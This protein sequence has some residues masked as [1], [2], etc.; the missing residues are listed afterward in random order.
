MLTG[1]YLALMGATSLAVPTQQGQH[2]HLSNYP[3]G[4]KWIARDHKDNVWLD[5]RMDSHLKVLCTSDEQSADRLVQILKKAS[6]INPHFLKQLGNIE[7]STKLEFNRHWGWGSSSTLIDLIAQWS[8]INPHDL[9]FQTLRGSGYDVACARASRPIL[10]SNDPH[11]AWI[12]VE[13][14]PPFLNELF[15]IYLNQKQNSAAEVNRFK[16]SR[17]SYENEIA[18]ISNISHRISNCYNLNEFQILLRQHEDIMSSVLQQA[19]VADK[20][21]KDV[22]GVFKSLGA[23]GGD[24]VLFAGKE[25]ALQE[26]K[27]RGFDTILR[28]SEIALL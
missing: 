5:V 26:I 15:L 22:P 13:W 14:K 8:N 7:I 3:D 2:L 4:I 17:G 9:L 18:L 25:E 20:W 11:P 23:W 16:S 12:E 21:F 28:F 24:F 27:N 19:T 6:E 1:E 10:Y